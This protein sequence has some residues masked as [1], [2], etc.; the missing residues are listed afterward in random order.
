MK[1]VRVGRRHEL[2]RIQ[3]I[4]YTPVGDDL[5]FTKPLRRLKNI[6]YTLVQ[7]RR[8]FQGRG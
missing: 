1:S 8:R 3:S 6:F 2:H 5:L 4:V 7:R